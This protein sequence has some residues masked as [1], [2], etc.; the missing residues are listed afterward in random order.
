MTIPIG[1]GTEAIAGEGKIVTAGGVDTHIHWICPQQAEEALVSGVTTMIGGGTG[2]AAGTNATTCTPG[3][4]YIARM[5]QAA[6][7]LPVNIGFLGK[8]N[9][10]NPDAL[11][12][13]IAAGAI[14]LKIHEDWGATPA[15]IDC[16][17]T[18]AEE[19]DIQVALHSDTL[20]ESGFVGGHAGGNWRSHDP[21]FSYRRGGRRSRPGYYHR[22]RAS[23]YSP[24]LHQPDA[25][26]YRQHH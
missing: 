17:L 1:V 25:A 8:G 15:A 26:L 18:V 23:P 2:P 5:L 9:G 21:Y 20:N 12:E 14:G 3:P 22:L 11:R 6:D 16:A 24:L 4:W 7:S 19:M 10:S 13:Q